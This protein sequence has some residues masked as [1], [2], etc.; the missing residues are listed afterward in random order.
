[1]RKT[2]ERQ[3]ESDFCF[4]F[5]MLNDTGLVYETGKKERIENGI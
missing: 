3:R 4:C 2:G 5:S 1:M